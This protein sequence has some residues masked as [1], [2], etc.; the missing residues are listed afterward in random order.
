MIKKIL[1][2][3]FIFFLIP[4]SSAS[5]A[6][7]QK[8]V[9]TP[10]LAPVVTG[11]EKTTQFNTTVEILPNSKLRVTE[12]IEV[13]SFGKQIKRGI[14]RDYPTEYVTDKGYIRTIDFKVL[15]VT[16]DGVADSYRLEGINK[17]E[18]IYIG[19][20]DYSLPNGTYK[21][22]LVYEV[23]GLVGFFGDTDELYYNLI[24]SG[25]TFGIDNSTSKVIF[26][27]LIDH[28]KIKSEAYSGFKDSTDQTK[29]DVTTYDKDGKTIV[30]VVLKS[31]LISLQGI[32]ILTQFPKGI[33]TQ[34]PPN[35]NELAI[36]YDGQYFILILGFL[37]V[38]G[39]SILFYLKFGK[40][41]LVKIPFPRFDIDENITP[42]YA[43]SLIHERFDFKALTAEIVSLAI[44]GYLQIDQG[45]NGSTYTIK[46][47]KDGK[48]NGIS[49]FIDYLFPSSDSLEFKQKNHNK[50]QNVIGT[51]RY[52]IEQ[53]FLNN[54]KF[55][56]SFLK[57]ISI[58]GGM[59]VVF[60]ASILPSRGL[61][62]IPTY[63]GMYL[64]SLLFGAVIYSVY[65][66]FSDTTKPVGAFTGVFNVIGVLVLFGTLG[67]CTFAST[68]LSNSTY[69]E[70][71]VLI[72]PSVILG[73]IIPTLKTYSK[74][75]LEKINYSKGL[76]MFV[77]A[78]ESE[79]VKIMGK[80]YTKDMTTFNKYFPYA[81]A[82]DAESKWT[83]DFKDVIE[84]SMVSDDENDNRYSP[85]N[86]IFMVG[87]SSS[88]TSNLSS[89]G[90]NISSTLQ[91]SSIDP[92]EYSSSSSGGGSHS[93]SSGGGGGGGGGSSGGGGGGG[94][95]GG[96]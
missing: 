66:R 20:S 29:T 13:I 32:T 72:V 36:K 76:Q 84:K 49:K 45:E 31:P 11:T 47:L 82:F 28:T 35:L 51:V 16:R 74:E 2:I 73:F 57:F 21:Y 71:I 55:N 17:G 90:E 54:F 69:I 75:G 52:A 79:R 7:T 56:N 78:T 96:W 37:I 15:S 70:L 3:L 59:F 38:I 92:T 42:I 8:K 67:F 24:P 48:E 63:I 93:F 60:V 87:D 4:I 39:L 40:E 14:F 26:P 68:G 5:A 89:I 44:H 50:I 18:R 85:S 65:V 77:T 80:E 86:W 23:T 12:D 94:G 6:T 1:I 81:I 43:R 95:G 25:W 30:Q 53:E 46:K 27:T 64:S 9:V 34:M 19:K 10:P 61:S 58:M 88:L 91:S 41:P 33:I 22:T 83:N 62:Q